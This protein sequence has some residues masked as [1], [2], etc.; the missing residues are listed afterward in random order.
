[1]LNNEPLLYHGHSLARLPQV[2]EHTGI[3]Y[4]SFVTG[5]INPFISKVTSARI[6]LERVERCRKVTGWAPRQAPALLRAQFKLS[7]LQ[8]CLMSG[9]CG[10]L[11]QARVCC[12]CFPAVAGRLGCPTPAPCPSL[13]HSKHTSV[14]TTMLHLERMVHSRKWRGDPGAESNR[15]PLPSHSPAPPSHSLP[16]MPSC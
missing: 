5:F 8:L 14:C 2:Q 1:M 7:Q 12:S 3:I 11:F 13:L 10:L 6:W 9:R 4:S 15:T 16:A